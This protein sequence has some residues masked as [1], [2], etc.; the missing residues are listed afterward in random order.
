MSATSIAETQ[1]R[2]ALPACLL[3]WLVPGAGH[4]YLG[5]TSR[6]LLFMGL[7]GTMFILG[8][9]MDARLQFYMGL[10]DPLAFFR[11]AAQI[12]IGLPY[13]IARSIGFGPGD[14]RSV[15]H[16][17]GN[18]FT[19][20]GGLLNILIVLDAYDVAHGRRR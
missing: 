18:T 5:R 10:E 9:A 2:S 3:A 12:A 11:S 14:V 4:L 17:Y 16:E 20:V 1:K 8:V 7:I 19:E 13:V 15:V 6:G